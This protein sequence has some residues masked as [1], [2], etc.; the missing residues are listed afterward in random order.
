VPGPGY[1]DWQKGSLVAKLEEKNKK[2]KIQFKSVHWIF[3]WFDEK[4]KKDQNAYKEL[5]MTVLSEKNLKWRIFWHFRYETIN[6]VSINKL[7]DKICIDL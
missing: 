1:Y 6:N 3:L 7:F 2:P 4:F 5:K